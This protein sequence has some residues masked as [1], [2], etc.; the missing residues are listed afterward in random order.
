MKL[1]SNGLIGC[2]AT[3][4]SLVASVE[5]RENFHVDHPYIYWGGQAILCLILLSMI[6]HALLYWDVK[7]VV[8]KKR[9]A[10]SIVVYMCMY[11]IAYVDSKYSFVLIFVIGMVE[12]FLTR[13]GFGMLKKRNVQQESNSSNRKYGRP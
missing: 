4:A 7:T 11:A 1:Y 8:S 3:V 12:V 9:L 2:V 10:L 5:L 6:I 13:K